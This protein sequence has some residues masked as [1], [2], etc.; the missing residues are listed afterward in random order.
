M[1]AVNPPLQIKD[2][3]PVCPD[4]GDRLTAEDFTVSE[5]AV[6]GEFEVLLCCPCGWEPGA[7]KLR[8]VDY[9]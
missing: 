3:P 5:L 6:D 9:L 2:V 7:V 8:F 4:C 1:N